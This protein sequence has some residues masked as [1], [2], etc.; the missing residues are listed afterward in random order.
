MFQPVGHC[1]LLIRDILL[2]TKRTSS[3][4]DVWTCVD[5]LCGRRDLVVV[6]PASHEADPLR[7]DVEFE[8]DPDQDANPSRVLNIERDVRSSITAPLSPT[9]SLLSPSN[10]S[11][12]GRESRHHRRE[13]E[14]DQQQQ[15]H[16]HG[17]G[18][19][20]R[21]NRRLRPSC[22]RLWDSGSG[23]ANGNDLSF[24]YGERPPRPRSPLSA[25]WGG[26]DCKELDG[27]VGKGGEEGVPMGGGGESDR[28]LFRRST[29]ELDKVGKGV[30]VRRTV[31]VVNWKS[32]M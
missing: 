6:C 18:S 2:S 12:L 13:V 10:H 30:F 16:Q 28:T 32:M 24:G 26:W 22:L 29:E 1:F 31:L 7:L 14:V 25:T 27:A 17:D 8:F 21:P 4:G 3:G 20:S 15:Q 11:P 5:R 23:G 9:P 19:P